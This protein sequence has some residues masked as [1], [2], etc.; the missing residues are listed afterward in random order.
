MAP[1]AGYS[2]RRAETCSFFCGS[3]GGPW[4]VTTLSV[5]MCAGSRHRCTRPSAAGVVAD[6]HKGLLPGGEVDCW[7]Y[8][9]RLP[10]TGV[11]SSAGF[12]W[13]DCG[14]IGGY[15][16]W[17]AGTIV[18]VGCAFIMIHIRL[19]E[20]VRHSSG[21]RDHRFHLG[22]PEKGLGILTSLSMYQTSHLYWLLVVV[23][24]GITYADYLS[25]EIDG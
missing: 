21:S 8:C 7:I 17:L 6:A 4:A 3:R 11:I 5:C 16:V 1:R 13:L 14:R 2:E 25:F 24:V 22:L 20:M 18:S 10:R 23:A 15:G 9:A 19:V 12:C